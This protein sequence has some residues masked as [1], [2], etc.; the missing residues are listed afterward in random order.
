M[1]LKKVRKESELKA[2]FKTWFSFFNGFMFNTPYYEKLMDHLHNERILNFIY[3]EKEDVFKCFR[4]THIN[5]LK[6]VVLGSEP[7]ID[8]TGNGMA[9][10]IDD[11]KT[12]KRVLDQL[13]VINKAIE[14]D[15]NILSFTDPSM[16]QIAKQGVLMLN[17]SLTTIKNMPL[18]HAIFWRLF[19][20]YTL[21]ELSK[22]QTGIIYVLLGKTAK[23]FTKYIDDKTNYVF[24]YEH[25]E[26][27]K[28]G[29]K[30]DCD[31]FSK[32]NQILLENNGKE[33]C[34]DWR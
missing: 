32:I 8:G 34:I 27:I 7:N 3:P 25:P 20:K 13:S 5:E 21:V 29:T 1:V 18:S 14:E 6:V 19:V 30:W 26:N 12:N 15:L 9:M 31:M 16:E 23:T 4:E 22:K 2:E 24:H 17:S 28:K 10:G 33:Y 11:F